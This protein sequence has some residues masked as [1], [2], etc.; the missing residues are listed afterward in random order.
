MFIILYKSMVPTLLEYATCIWS[1]YLKEDMRRLKS[2]QRRATKFVK[3]ICHLN[4]E[5]RLRSLGLPTL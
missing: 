3:I 2:V 4:N 5:D 1:S